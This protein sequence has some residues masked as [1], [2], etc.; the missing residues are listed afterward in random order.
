MKIMFDLNVLLDVLQQR[1][2]HF[3]ASA[4]ACAMAV[5]KEISGLIPSHAL[6]TIAYIVRRHAGATKEKEALDW[7]LAN[8]RVAPA[9]HEHMLRA[10]NY[11]WVDFEDA[12]TAALAE[13]NGCHVILSRNVPDFP[14]SSVP[15]VTPG[16]F[17]A[18]KAH[19][20]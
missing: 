1:E 2:P 3:A 18:G 11:G 12:V 4:A 20:R 8:F 13:A 19:A 16:E 10:R 17:V 9:S 15:A 6:T 14:S 5:R 7:L